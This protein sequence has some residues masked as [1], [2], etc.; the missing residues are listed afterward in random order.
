MAGE[1]RVDAGKTTFAAGLVRALARRSVAASAFKPRAGNDYW[2]DHDDVRAATADGR[3]YGK[4]VR[5]L[6]D[7]AGSDATP[8]ARNPVH[9]LWRPAPGR[10]GLLGEADRTFLVDRVSTPD[11]PVWL[12]NADADVPELV[13]ERLPISEA[14]AV[15]SVAAFNDAMREYH[16]PALDS[17]AA[18][19]RATDDA[20]VESYG[21][22]ANPLAGVRYDAVATVAPGR[23]RVYDGDRWAVACE[24]A[25]GGPDE[26]RMEEHV[27]RVTGMVD[28]VSTHAL[29]ALSGAERDDA[30]A[31]ADA[32]REV[33]ETLV[34][35]ARE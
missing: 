21:D 15:D 32:N 12:Y 5:R 10:V 27:G 17:L 9:R 22:V 7:A 4:D 18:D 26:G 8:E 28:P 34:A 6:L 24:A 30:D 31:V 33:Y 35:T 25:A 16:L 29:P 1:A 3:L 19:V 2:Y 14:L 23:A 20:V 13:R 11:G